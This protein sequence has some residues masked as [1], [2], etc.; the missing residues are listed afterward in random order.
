MNTNAVIIEPNEPATA[1]VIWLH[2]LGENGHD[3][4]PIV[5]DLSENLTR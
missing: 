4:E 2:G 5:T 3:F 1:S